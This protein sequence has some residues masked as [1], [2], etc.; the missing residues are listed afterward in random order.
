MIKNERNLTKV[1]LYLLLLINCLGVAYCSYAIEFNF[2]D[3]QSFNSGTTFS[4]GQIDLTL[5]SEGIL[6][7]EGGFVR[8]DRDNGINFD[9]N[10]T[11]GAQ[12][13]PYSVNMWVYI[14]E[15]IYE[16]VL[17]WLPFEG[18][19]GSSYSQY[20]KSNCWGTVK[21]DG[22]KRDILF[23]CQ[24]DSTRN[25]TVS[26]HANNSKRKDAWQYF[27]FRYKA[28]STSSPTSY[29]PEVN[30][31]EVGLYNQNGILINW[32]SLTIDAEEKLTSIPSIGRFQNVSNG[33]YYFP[34][35]GLVYK[36]SFYNTWNDGTPTNRSD[37]VD[38][39]KNNYFVY[40]KL[41]DMDQNTH[42]Y[43]RIR[44]WVLIYFYWFYSIGLEKGGQ[45]NSSYFF[46]QD[47]FRRMKTM[48]S[49]YGWITTQNETSYTTDLLPFKGVIHYT[50]ETEVFWYEIN[51]ALDL[52]FKSKS[53]DN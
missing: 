24:G 45:T 14:F 35:V 28:H 9:G 51:W 3:D 48:V 33:E 19:Y 7:A 39:Y 20:V 49:S 36:I 41:G 53:A 13:Y 4:K 12:P 30:D 1:H 52:F 47:L 38:L 31:V 27:S 46:N 26:T 37:L 50:I 21:F 44:K 23:S 17:F 2:T 42:E 15:E 11:L 43:N 10:I 18:Y 16:I 34:L 22:A 40:Y 5:T 29:A 8:T 25:F 6:D 32:T